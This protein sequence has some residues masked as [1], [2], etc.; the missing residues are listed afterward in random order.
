M[1]R[2]YSELISLVRNW[3]NRDTEV[4]P[5]SI[6]ADTLRYAADKAYRHLRIAPL[7]HTL[8]YDPASALIEEELRVQ[9]T[10]FQ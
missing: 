9:T 7:E 8:Y 5:N 2:T 3:S 4:L 1:A 6:I 10:D